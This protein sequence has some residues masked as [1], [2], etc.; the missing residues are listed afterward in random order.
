MMTS[1]STARGQDP[2]ATK[3]AGINALFLLY[4]EGINDGISM[5]S[6]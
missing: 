6:N 2:D 4:F 3:V 5:Q 1:V